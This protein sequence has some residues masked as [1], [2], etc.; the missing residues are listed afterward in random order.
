MF[1]R[2]LRIDGRRYRY[3]ETLPPAGV[4]SRGALVLIHAFP[5]SAALFLPQEGLASAGWRVVAPELRQ[6]G[7]GDGDPPAVSVDDY[8]G[9]ILALLDGLGVG[10][11]VVCGVSMGGYIAFAILRRAPERV[12]AVILANTR[13][14]AD[15]PTSLE[16][17]RRMLAS[18]AD[19]GVAAVAGE[20]IPKLLG[21]TTRAERADLVESLR[22]IILGNR[23]EA[24][25][26]AIAALMSRPDSGPQ[27]EAIACP[28]LVIV[29]D[30]DEVTPPDVARDM[31]ASIRGSELVVIP[32]AGHL[33]SFEQ[34]TAFNDAVARFLAHRV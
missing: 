20:M 15:P 27:L 33:S 5:T 3:G 18:M 22:R 8:A 30:E 21:R 34:P 10:D 11:A 32:G 16:G 19:G 7:D 6:F 28:A 24:I 13:P 9:D 2:E 4:A 31:H 25:A 12:R 26:G 23:P 29:G 1:R 17:R 14:Q